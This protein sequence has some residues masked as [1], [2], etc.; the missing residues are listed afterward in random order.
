MVGAR[1]LS[2]HLLLSWL[3][4]SWAIPPRP[5]FT[6]HID[7]ESVSSEFYVYQAF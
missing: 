2:V 5:Y 4:I 3:A 1:L 7:F 6:F